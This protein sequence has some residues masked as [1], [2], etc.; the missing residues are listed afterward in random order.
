MRTTSPIRY[1][2]G[3][4]PDLGGYK[5]LLHQV[6]RGGGRRAATFGDSQQRPGGIEDSTGPSLFVTVT[7]ELRVD[8]VCWP[9]E[10]FALEGVLGGGSP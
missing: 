6:F 7:D 1:P 10:S 8:R 3:I 2:L 5:S 9:P 4:L